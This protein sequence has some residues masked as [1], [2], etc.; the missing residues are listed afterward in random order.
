[1]K[2]KKIVSVLLA[3]ACV[4]SLAAC[5]SKESS[6]DSSEKE[7]LVMATNAEFP[8]YEYHE[9]DDIV[10]IDA[11]IAAA[12]AEKL[13]MELK[14]EDMAFDSII[15][16][17]TAGKAD[18]G[19]AGMTVTEDRLESVNFSDTYA[20]ATQV[21]IVKED[22]D[23]TGPDDLAGKTVGVQ[24]GTTGDIY[25]S[26]IEDATVE[27]YNKGF[28]A[29]QALTQGKIDAVIIDGEP[30]KEFVK[31]AE[32]LKILDEAFTEEEYAIAIAKD[33]TDLEEKIN[34]ALGELKDS[35][36][37]DEII[38]KYIKADAE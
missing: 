19:V 12:I 22:S 27:Q 30:A 1:M 33:N 26:D 36:K 14:I 32:G 3:A 35:G 29:V 17:V 31:E 24:L 16:A 6:E 28:E 21:V 11:E 37:L 38:A 9:G 7:T 23:I 5:G 20:T 2:L 25:A 15:P 8:P 4:F 10:G 18:I 13:G 34:D